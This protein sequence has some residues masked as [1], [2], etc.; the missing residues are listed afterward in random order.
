MSFPPWRTRGSAWGGSSTEW[1]GQDPGHQAGYVGAQLSMPGNPWRSN[2]DIWEGFSSPTCPMQRH[3]PGLAQD[4]AL[5]TPQGVS[6]VAQSCLAIGLDTIFF[7]PRQTQQSFPKCP[8]GSQVLGAWEWVKG[9]LL[10]LTEGR[11]APGPSSPQPRV[12]IPSNPT[13]QEDLSTG[14]SCPGGRCSPW[15]LRAGRHLYSAHE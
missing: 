8:C 13:G 1:T 15:A 4:L 5:R 7:P 2:K 14:G 12:L 3:V 11:E 10:P 9:I 6:A